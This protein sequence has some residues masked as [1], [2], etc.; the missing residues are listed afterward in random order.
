MKKEIS[1]IK[2]RALLAKQRLKMGYWQRMQ[3]D[4]DKIM[5][6]TN[7]NELIHSAHNARMRE[8]ERDTRRALGDD[9]AEKDELLYS[10]VREMLDR[11]EDVMNPIGLLMDKE[12]FDHMDANNKQRYILELSAKFR[13][14]KDRYYKEKSK[15]V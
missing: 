4:R 13:E 10:K 7:N 14:L 9:F 11:D 2:R 12:A 5:G 1:E 15:Y 3:E 8:F 6:A